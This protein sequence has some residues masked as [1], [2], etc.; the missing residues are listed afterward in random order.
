MI[1]WLLVLGPL[2]T[3]ISLNFTRATPDLEHFE[4]ATALRF[5]A[6]NLR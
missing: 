4:V 3:L 2:H 6:L 5:L 1:D